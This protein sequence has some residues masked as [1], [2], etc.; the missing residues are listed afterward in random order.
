[1]GDDDARQ[2]AS[3]EIVRKDGISRGYLLCDFRTSTAG[4]VFYPCGKEPFMI[5]VIV[6]HSVSNLDTLEARHDDG[7][8]ASMTKAVAG[9]FDATLVLDELRRLLLRLIRQGHVVEA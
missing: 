6:W 3:E 8:T 2:E 9:P 4:R 1:M 5:V 7:C